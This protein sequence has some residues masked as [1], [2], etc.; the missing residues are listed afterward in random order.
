[1]KYPFASYNGV[2]WY[3]FRVEIPA[4][5]SGKPLTL[6]LG[7]VDDLDTTFFNGE[8]VGVTGED[9]P[10]YW[11]VRRQYPVPPNLVRFGAEKVIAAE[12]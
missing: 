5:W 6:Q 11:A 2:A 8:Q 12:G 1:M 3:R 10:R 4:A 7:V 9:T